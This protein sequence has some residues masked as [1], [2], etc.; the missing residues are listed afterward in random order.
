MNTSN[1]Q[2]SRII[3]RPMDNFPGNPYY[4]YPAQNQS[5]AFSFSNPNLQRTGVQPPSQPLTQSKVAMWNPNFMGANW[6]NA[7]TQYSEVKIT[8]SC[9]LGFHRNNYHPSMTQYRISYDEFNGMIDKIEG[10]AWSFKWIQTLYILIVLLTTFATILLVIGIFLEPG[11]SVTDETT[12]DSLDSASTGLIVTSVLLLLLGN[13]LLVYLIVS[14]LRRY[15]FKIRKLLQDENQHSF[16]S[17]NIHWLASEHCSYIQI[18]CL[19][20]SA[21]QYYMMMLQ[22]NQ[23]KISKEYAEKMKKEE[24]KK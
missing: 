12:F 16:Y 23:L 2:E 6:E 14:S 3:D 19:P 18:K 8:R 10:C 15:E 1:F 17:R 7:Q 11:E 22:T 20:V 13:G 4:N 21:Q 24:E 9:W 5:N